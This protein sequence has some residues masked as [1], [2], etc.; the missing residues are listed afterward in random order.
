MEIFSL[1][2]I[3][4]VKKMNKDLDI[5]NTEIELDL[6][7]LNLRKQTLKRLSAKENYDQTIK[8][9]DAE[10]ERLSK[11]I[12]DLENRLNELKGE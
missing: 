5:M 6:Q 3:I 9:I 7:K 4:T 11:K 12:N 8:G 2:Y 1:Q 10:E